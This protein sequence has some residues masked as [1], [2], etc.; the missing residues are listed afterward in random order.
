MSN[1]M[2]PF[3]IY[4]SKSGLYLAITPTM[5]LKL[6]SGSLSTKLTKLTKVKHVSDAKVTINIGLPDRQ[7]QSKEFR[8]TIKLASKYL[9]TY[10]QTRDK[11]YRHL[12]FITVMG[13]TDYF[14]KPESRN[15]NLRDIKKHLKAG[16]VSFKTYYKILSNEMKRELIGKRKAVSASADVTVLQSVKRIREH[17]N[18]VH[19]FS[20]ELDKLFE[21]ELNIYV[22]EMKARSL[23]LHGEEQ[24]Q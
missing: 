4:R 7:D 2:T 16:N 6:I 9:L 17:W 15:F 14:F 19:G 8:D 5:G 18:S 12:F 3:E 20:K 21:K 13:A 11:K 24:E 23:W 22:S 10:H 1:K